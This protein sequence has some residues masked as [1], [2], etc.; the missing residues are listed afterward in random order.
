MH[1]GM[2]SYLKSNRNH[3]AKQISYDNLPASVS[4]KSTE[5]NFDVLFSIN[6]IS[7]IA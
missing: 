6:I 3:T 1:F 4:K 2:K 7:L 5:F